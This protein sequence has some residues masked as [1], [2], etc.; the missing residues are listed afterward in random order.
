LP[1]LRENEGDTFRIGAALLERKAGRVGR[2][3]HRRDAPYNDAPRS[4]S[5]HPSM[6]EIDYY[7][8]LGINRGA[9]AEEIRKAYK[10][11]A[12]KYHPDVRPGDKDAA[13]QF[14]K[15]Q[16]AYSVLGDADKRVQYDR[17]GHAFDGGRGGGPYRTAW[18]SGPDGT[19]AVDLSDLFS[20]FF[21]GGAEGFR[22]GTGGAQFE[23][24]PFPGGF[25]AGQAGE[26]HFGHAHAATEPRKGEDITFEVTVPFQVAAEGGNHG[27]QI[28]RGE[29]TERINVK[30]PAGVQ[31][32]ST[33]RLAGQ[34]QPSPMGGP[35]GDLLLTVQVAPHPYFYREGNNLLVDVP[36]TP[37]EAALGTKIEVPTL[38]EGHVNVK[39]PPGTSSGTRLRLR[40]KGVPHPKTHERG[41]Q[42]VVVKIVI[43]HETSEAA[44]KL[45]SELA[46]IESQTPRSGLW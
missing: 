33:I 26:A 31:D 19:H 25:G 23:R 22:G 17:Y 13:D 14:K 20:Q 11:L 27:L 6:P 43:P 2:L 37:S 45:Y 40:G 36:I 24:H 16:Q 8:T 10:K 44:K 41:D 29:N 46:T 1:P 3:N 9:S 30:I 12:R 5:R 4:R 34:G 38:S 18:A 15:V 21:G 35:A 7:K 42:F 28:R 39:V 32:G